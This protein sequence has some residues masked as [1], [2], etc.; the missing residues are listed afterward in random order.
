MSFGSK[1]WTKVIESPGLRIT[2]GVLGNILTGI[3]CGAFIT[4]I[5]ESGTL[6]WLSFYKAKSF[7]FLALRVI[8]WVN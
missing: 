3:L 7:Y 4:E 6:N 5:T 2:V 8:E 1:A